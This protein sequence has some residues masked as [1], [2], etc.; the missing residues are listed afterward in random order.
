MGKEQ[1]NQNISTPSQ[2]HEGMIDMSSFNSG[3]YILK[4]KAGERVITKKVIKN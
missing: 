1:V 4:F 3:A 2:T